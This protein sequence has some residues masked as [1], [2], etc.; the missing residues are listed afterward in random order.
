MH[1]FQ[2]ETSVWRVHDA[3]PP[4]VVQLSGNPDLAR[5]PSGVETEDLRSTFFQRANHSIRGRVEVPRQDEDGHAA[6]P[7][8]SGQKS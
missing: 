3:T 4:T 1:R 7:G 8:S 2:L 6:V 5:E